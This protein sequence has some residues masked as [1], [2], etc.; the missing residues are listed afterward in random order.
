MNNAKLLSYSET[1]VEISMAVALKIEP[2]RAVIEDSREVVSNCIA[3]AH[4]FEKLHAQTDWDAN[5]WIL[6]VEAF[7]DER[8]NE[9]ISPVKNIAK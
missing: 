6:T 7:A 2:I 9:I 1:L 5:D 4:E 8:I 3:W